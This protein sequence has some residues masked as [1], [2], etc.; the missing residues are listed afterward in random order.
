MSVVT[1]SEFRKWA[2]AN[3]SA[4]SIYF[5]FGNH[6]SVIVRADP[7]IFGHDR[8]YQPHDETERAYLRDS[9]QWG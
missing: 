5:S 9:A 3:D 7:G 8:I 1:S 4:E 6:A 2:T